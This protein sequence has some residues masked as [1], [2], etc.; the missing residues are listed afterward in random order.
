MT[1]WRPRSTSETANGSLLEGLDASTVQARDAGRKRVKQS[2]RQRVVGR[3]ELL[4]C[5]VRPHC[6]WLGGLVV[7]ENRDTGYI[8]LPG[9]DEIMCDVCG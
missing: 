6:G 9:R 1:R 4:L 2:R 7:V 3:P 5:C 8:S